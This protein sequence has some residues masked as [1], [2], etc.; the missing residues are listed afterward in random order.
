M[1]TYLKPYGHNNENNGCEIIVRGDDQ[2]TFAKIL[3]WARS[4]GRP[5]VIKAERTVTC[6]IDQ[7]G[8]PFRTTKDVMEVVYK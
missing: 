8:N 3:D 7:W 1:S 5:E 6:G 4:L 2:S